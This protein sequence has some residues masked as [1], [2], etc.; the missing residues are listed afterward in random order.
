MR[1]KRINTH[2]LAFAA[3]TGAAYAVLTIALAPISYGAVQFRISEA[4][5]ILP[6]FIPDT[7]AGLFI[8]CLAANIMT[9]N[10]FDIIFGSLATL[11]AGICTALT[12]RMGR[13]AAVKLLACLPPVIINA[14][15]VGAVITGAYNGM[16]ITGHMGIYLI[17]ALQV[18]AGEAAVMYAL[19]FPLMLYLPR[20][21]F[22]TE[23]INKTENRRRDR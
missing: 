19:G 23:L 14:L 4:L 17:N 5:C 6:F 13:S 9:G 12:G 2:S 3:I 21:A 7:A 11:L 10:V 16:S 18:G 22:F 1:E 15:V 20:K 8:G